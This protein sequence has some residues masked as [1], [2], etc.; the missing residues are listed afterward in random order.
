MRNQ[1][2]ERVDIMLGQLY[3]ERRLLKWPTPWL[4]QPKL[5]GDRCRA[6]CKN[7]EWT[8]Y[9]S[10]GLTRDLPTILVAL[11]ENFGMSDIELD[12]ELYVHGWPHERIRSIVSRTQNPH[13]DAHLMQY[14]V[15]DIVDEH[16]EQFERIKRLQALM[17]ECYSIELHLIQTWRCNSIKEIE[18]L[19]QAFLTAGYEGAIIRHPFECYIRKK[20]AKCFQKLKPRDE[21]RGVVAQLIQEE[22]IDGHPKNSLG[23]CVV[24]FPSTT[25]DVEV[26]LGTGFTNEERQRFWNQPE[27]L[28][29]KIVEFTYSELSPGGVPKM[30]VFKRIVNEYD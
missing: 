6:V 7:G 1:P 14:H 22:S 21:L 16:T 23:S 9:S 18:T 5:N 26:K 15:F 11:Y 25:G 8:L 20:T 24:Y 17:A 12:G 28:V 30:P 13:E 4:I 27:T 29:G 3:S 19:Y 10:T 2:R